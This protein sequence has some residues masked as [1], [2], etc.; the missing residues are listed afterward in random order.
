MSVR[1]EFPCCALVPN[2]ATPCRSPNIEHESSSAL[3]DHLISSI[4]VVAPFEDHLI[5][6]I[7]VVAPFEDHLISSIGVVAPFPN[8]EHRSGSA[9]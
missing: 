7:G 1:E 9:L 2:H 5:S 3:E 6:S 8:I 4:G